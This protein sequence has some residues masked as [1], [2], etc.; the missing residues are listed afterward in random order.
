M[1]KNEVQNDLNN[2]MAIDQSSVETSPSPARL[3][4]KTDQPFPLRKTLTKVE[5][6]IMDARSVKV[7]QLPAE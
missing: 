1:N 3:E 2:A 4:F 7:K 5:Q 6:E